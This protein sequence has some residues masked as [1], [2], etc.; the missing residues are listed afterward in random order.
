MK[1]ISMVLG[2]SRSNLADRLTGARAERKP[3]YNKFKDLE[4]LPLIS[5]AICTEKPSYGYR[6][7]TAL[8]NRKYRA[9]NAPILNHKRVYR[10]M[11]QK[12]AAF[13]KTYWQANA[14]S[15]W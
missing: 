9:I 6:R 14:Y 3:R 10:L 15:R 11:R 5:E 1:T 8:L 7:V 12:S 13:T 2:V 4:I